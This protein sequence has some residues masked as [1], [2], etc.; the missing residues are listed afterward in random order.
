MITPPEDNPTAV[1][2]AAKNPAVSDP[3]KI[4]A[5]F[6]GKAARAARRP[7]IPRIPIGTS[8]SKSGIAAVLMPERIS[9]QNCNA[10]PAPET[11]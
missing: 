5:G 8:S 1:S 4:R 11:E 7:K 10:C 2:A 6:L 3:V 9:F